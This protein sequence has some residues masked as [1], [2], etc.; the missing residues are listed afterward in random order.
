MADKASLVINEGS[1]TTV[2]ILA[3]VSYVL[4]N[5][6][7]MPKPEAAKT[8]K[9]VLLEVEIEQK[10]SV[11]YALDLFEN[12]SLDFVD[13]LIIAKHR[14]IVNCCGLKKS[15]FSSGSLHLFTVH[16]NYIF[17][18]KFKLFKSP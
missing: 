18:D 1:F 6:Y 9:A 8:I 17:G 5:V 10:D 15:V 14:V 11:L 4:R 3:E 2:E 7:K 13:C 16:K 12:Y